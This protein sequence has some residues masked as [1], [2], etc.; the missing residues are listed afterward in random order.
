MPVVARRAG[1]RLGQADGTPGLEQ[2]KRAFDGFG[3]LDPRLN[4]QIRD[5]GRIGRLGRVVGGVMQRCC[6]QPTRQ[7][8]LKAAVNRRLV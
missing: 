1:L 8:A 3:C 5:E 2:G 6:S 7:T 4:Q